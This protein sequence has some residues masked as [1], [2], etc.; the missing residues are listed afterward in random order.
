[1]GAEELL[2][3]IG[4]VIAIIAFV[5]EKNREYLVLKFSNSDVLWLL[6]G[7]AFLHFL[8]SF[9][10]LLENWCKRLSYFT[11]KK[12]IPAFAWAYLLTLV[13]IALTCY[14]VFFAFFPKSNKHKVI[15]F[16]EKLNLNMEQPF[17]LNLLE[18]FHKKD[19]IDYLD[20]YSKVEV[21]VESEFDYEKK[22]TEAYKKTINTNRLDY[23]SAVYN[24]IILD[25]VF[26]SN[27]ANVYPYFFTDFISKLNKK[28]F[29]N[30]EFI[31]KYFSIMMKSKNH[32]FFREIRN[33]QNQGEGSKYRLE[34][35]HKILCKDL[36]GKI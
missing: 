29:S 33:T 27:V 13:L 3:M 34:K 1:M 6:L 32:H 8:V 11:H 7:F 2:A 14:K 10:W 18:K 35:E 31:N 24:K 9:D 19:I 4:L 23:A 21:D 28:S 26:L 30:E 17:L 20:K 5:S 36:A 12:G 22:F 25:E 16:Y 15:N